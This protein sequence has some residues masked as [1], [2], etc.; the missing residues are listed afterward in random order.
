MYCVENI[1][2]DHSKC[3]KQCSGLVVSSYD[4]YDIEKNTDLI[5]FVGFNSILLE[6]LGKRYK[7][8]E[9]LEGFVLDYALQEIKFISL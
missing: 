5:N 3:L 6:F 8:P 7:L 9:E 2:F 1:T 4:K